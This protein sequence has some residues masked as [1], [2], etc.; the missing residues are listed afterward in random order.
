MH[1]AAP[2]RSGR[3]TSAQRLCCGC[4]PRQCSSPPKPEGNSSPSS[5]GGSNPRA[6]DIPRHSPG[7]SRAGCSD[8]ECG[9]GRSRPRRRRPGRSAEPWLRLEHRQAPAGAYTSGEREERTGRTL[10]D[11][12]RQDVAGRAGWGG[13]G[14]HPPP[15]CGVAAFRASRALQHRPWARFSPPLKHPAFPLLC[16]AVHLADSASGLLSPGFPKAGCDL[17]LCHY[18][19]D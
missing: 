10:R 5:Y 3:P 1:T 14:L 13:A 19:G 11:R 17:E 2:P 12:T 9:P 6:P 4:R 15:G 8:T 7:R 18:C 16:Q